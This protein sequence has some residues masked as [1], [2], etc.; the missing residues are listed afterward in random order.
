MQLVRQKAPS[1]S[2]HGSVSSSL[3]VQAEPLEMAISDR[4]ASIRASL[5]MLGKLTLTTWAM[6]RFTSPLII[7]STSSSSHKNLSLTVEMRSA[8]CVT[9]LLKEVRFHRLEHAGVQGRSRVVIKVERGHHDS[10]RAL[11][12]ENHSGPHFPAAKVSEGR[13]LAYC[14]RGC[15]AIDQFTQAVAVDCG[16]GHDRDRPHGVAFSR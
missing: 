12:I 4:T 10:L 15:P 3:K 5:S 14:D 13:S 7:N 6:V 16:V 11:M 2:G 1:L 8:P 9:E